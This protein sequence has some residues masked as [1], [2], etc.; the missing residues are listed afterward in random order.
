[1]KVT[2]AKSLVSS[3]QNVKV[4]LDGNQ[5]GVEIT[6]DEDSWLLTFTYMHSGHKVQ[7]N[8]TGNAEEN[9]FSWTWIAAATIIVVAVSMGLVVW[10]TKKNAVANESL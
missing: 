7:I 6:S 3:V 5:L 8:L 4:Y 2:M 1:V 10:R 9:T